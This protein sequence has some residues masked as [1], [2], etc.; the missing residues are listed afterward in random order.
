MGATTPPPTP[1]KVTWNQ[2]QMAL[3]ANS[4]MYNPTTTNTQY[5]TQTSQPD[6]TALVNATMQQMVGRNATPDEISR[7]GQELLAAER[8]NQGTYKGTT[9]YGETGKRNTVTGLQTTT[10]VDA[11]AFLSSIIRGTGEAQ[12][13]NVMNTYMGA[14]QQMTDQFKGS[15]SG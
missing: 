9:T 13:Y 5:L 12:A 7:Y 11:Q 1:P 10:G 8:A 4:P 3:G 2:S 14:L 15:Y 6:I